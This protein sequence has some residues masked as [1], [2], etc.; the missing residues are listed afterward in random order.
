[1]D[2]LGN[3]SYGICFV[4]T[5]VDQQVSLIAKRTSKTLGKTVNNVTVVNKDREQQLKVETHKGTLRKALK[6]LDA[7]GEELDKWVAT[8]GVYPAA[9]TEYLALHPTTG[10]E[11]R[12]LRLDNSFQNDLN[13]QLSNSLL[14][15]TLALDTR[16]NSGIR[17]SVKRTNFQSYLPVPLHI[18]T[19]ISKDLP[20][21]EPSSAKYSASRLNNNNPVKSLC[22]SV[23]LMS[24][25]ESQAQET[26]SVDGS[27]GY[28]RFVCFSPTVSQALYTADNPL[29]DPSQLTCTQPDL[30]ER[31]ATVEMVL[32]SA[33]ECVGHE[34]K[35]P[36]H[37]N[38]LT[39]PNTG[40]SIV[41]VRMGCAF[42]HAST[43]ALCPSNSAQIWW[44]SSRGVEWY[45]H[46]MGEIPSPAGRHCREYNQLARPYHRQLPN[47]TVKHCAMSGLK[48]Y[49]QM[50]ND[51]LDRSTY[52]RTI[53]A[54]AAR[55]FGNQQPDEPLYLHRTHT[56]CSV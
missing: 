47:P 7:V 55:R 5:E 25:E 50:I 33:K 56:R 3:N 32:A 6:G 44:R 30:R 52:H 26:T 39:V 1:M 8:H 54:L 40:R 23:L 35:E 9:E 16:R 46:V 49:S 48:N 19:C 2:L 15:S 12:P 20:C 27:S 22:G 18:E 41:A 31:G 53:K 29:L 34:L 13:S 17:F 24:S 37:Y 21:W 45:A 10:D 11:R 38:I 28:T 43:E 14:A 36:T 4:G 42:F 51:I